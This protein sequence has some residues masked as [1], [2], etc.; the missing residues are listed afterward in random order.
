[1]NRVRNGYCVNLTRETTSFP[2]RKSLNIS[3]GLLAPWCPK[4]KRKKILMQLL[5]KLDS[6]V[7]SIPLE[8]SNLKANPHKK[9]RKTVH[10]NMI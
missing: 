5:G 3:F 2:C 8:S 10:N 7:L 4:T 9:K 1:M 6:N